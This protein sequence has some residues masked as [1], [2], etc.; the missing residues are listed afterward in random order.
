MPQLKK[1]EHMIEEI[2]IRIQAL[3]RKK[4]FIL[5][6]IDGRCASGKTTLASQLKERLDCNVIHADEFFLRPSQRTAERLTTPGGNVDYERLLEEVILPLKAN[7]EFAYK[8]YD[9][10][11]GSLKEPIQVKPNNITI[12]EGSYSCHPKLW[13]Y[14]DLRIFMT[15]EECLQKERIKERN[16]EM[17]EV[18]FQK[19]I[20]MEETY[21][22]TYA[23]AERC[24]I[25]IE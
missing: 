16:K 2:V 10:R 23:I 18:F 14:Y 25:P 8:P 12:I 13:D 15:I 11:T 19:W 21:F 4:E 1:T 6:A 3:L 22:K 24:D 7:R 9:C 5:V 20:P 17:A